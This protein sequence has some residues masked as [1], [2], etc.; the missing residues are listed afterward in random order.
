MSSKAQNVKKKVMR[1]TVTG[2]IERFKDK[3]PKKRRCANC[4]ELLHGVPHQ[5]K[6]S[7][8]RKLS[9][10]EKRPSVRFGGI[11]CSK[12]RRTMFEEAIKV[13]EGVKKKEDVDLSIKKYVN[14]IKIGV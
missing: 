10:T 9:K 5:K 3:K 2:V 7:E 8:I 1:K 13:K 12:C 14:E 6:T 4:K 11:L